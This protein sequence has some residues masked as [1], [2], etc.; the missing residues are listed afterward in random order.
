MTMNFETNPER[1]LIFH[2][3]TWQVF[4]TKIRVNDFYAFFDLLND[5][6]K[7]IQI[8]DY[9]YIKKEHILYFELKADRQDY[10]PINDRK[11]D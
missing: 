5:D 1:D 3:D 11:Y 7:Y 2:L 6:D 9:N 10:L 4:N 8:D